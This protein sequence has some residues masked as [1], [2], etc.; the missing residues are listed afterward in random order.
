MLAAR[1]DAA[2]ADFERVLQA[3]QRAAAF[4]RARRVGAGARS[5]CSTSNSCTRPRE[6]VRGRLQLVERLVP[7]VA[8]GVRRAGRRRAAGR[9]RL[10]GRV[11][12]RAARHRPTSTRS[13]TC[14]RDALVR[15]P[16]GG[17]RP[18]RHARRARTATSCK[19]TID[20]LDARTQAS[21][22]E[23]RTPR[24]RACGSRAID[25]VHELTGTPPV[26]LLDDVFSEL[27]ARALERA[28]AQPAAG[29]D[30]A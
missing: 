8:R 11:G 25:V 20:G 2:R 3:T 30:A 28:R 9:A 6:L 19:L 17:D 14:L 7:A 10:R 23:Q 24:A 26:L 21:Q 18:R 22:G 16:P 27:D 13:T 4:G 12:A 15:P 5:T 1:Y 29:P